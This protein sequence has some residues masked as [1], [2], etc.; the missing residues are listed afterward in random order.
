MLNLRPYQSDAVANLRASYS[1]KKRAPLLVMPTGGGKTQVFAYITQGSAA[2]GKRVLICAHRRELIKQASRKLSEA[3][4]EH[5]IIAP[6]FTPT[7]DACQIAS[8]QTIANRLDKI[9]DFDLIVIDEG[10]HVPSPSYMKL[11]ASQPNAK[12]LLVTA[13]PERLDGKGLGVQAGG[14]CDDMVMGPSAAELMDDGYLVKAK[15]FAP[16]H[17]PDLSGVKLRMGDYE[18]GALADVMGKQS[19]VGDA[20]D[21]YRRLAPGLPAIVFCVSVDHARN[22]AETF[23]KAGWRAVSADGSMSQAER[24]AAIGSLS[25]KTA[26][27]LVVCDLCSEGLD[28]TGISVVIFL[29]AS[30]SLVNYLQWTG[31]GLRPIYAP[32][33]DQ[34]TREGRLA[35]IATSE[36]KNLIILDHAGLVLTHGMPDEDRVWSLDGRP[37]KEAAPPTKQCRECFAIYS[38]RP[39]CP[40]CGFSTAAEDKATREMEV[41]AGELAE[42][43]AERLE[44]MRKTPL[45]KLL[46]GK[47]SNADL[48]EIRK[49]KKYHPRWVSHVIRERGAHA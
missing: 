23:R 10:H 36:K 5:G 17:G 25:A 13:S 3:G 40:E 20:V 39:V 35:G 16:A 41:V 42:M 26:D 46:T 24:D 6:G 30:K 34:S 19:L 27:L 7:R 38:P 22:T 37:K 2:K 21:H 43:T 32:G 18:K 33:F 1:A 49:A 4:V 15:V 14:V 9:G 31:R 29:R 45:S 48:E 11:I 8:I 44:T 47:E 12:F 28:I